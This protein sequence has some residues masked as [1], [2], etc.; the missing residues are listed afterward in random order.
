[1]IRIGFTG[2]GTGGHFYPLIAV[3]EEIRHKYAEQDISLFYFGDSPY[4]AEDL[5][6]SNIQFVKISS[7]KSRLYSSFSNFLDYFKVS[8]GVI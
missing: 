8:W 4:S 1:M 2:G 5:K 6:N 3:A 7:G